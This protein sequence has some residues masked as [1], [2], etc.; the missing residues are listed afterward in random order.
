MSDH[1]IGVAVLNWR[2]G[3]PKGWLH[4]IGETGDG[5]RFS[6][7][8]PVVPDGLPDPDANCPY[9]RF[10]GDATDVLQCTPS[11]RISGYIE[12][13]GAINF[14]NTLHWSVRHVL[15]HDV[16]GAWADENWPPALLKKINAPL[17]YGHRIG[18]Y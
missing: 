9:W 5:R 8:V 1:I 15:F 6:H 11:V 2:Q 7:F 4:F 3:Q 14:H 16:R 18:N 10:K 12:E 13:F 17:L